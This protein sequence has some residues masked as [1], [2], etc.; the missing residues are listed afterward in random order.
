MNARYARLSC[1]SLMLT[2]VAATGLAGCSGSAV[3]PTAY[4]EYNARDGTF[5]CARPEGWE[6]DGGGKNG[7]Q[8]A[9]F[10]SGPA[11]IRI[12][13]DLVGSLM[14]GIPSGSLPEGMEEVVELEPVHRVHELEKRDA[15]QKYPGYAEVGSPQV[16]K[17]T[18]GPARQ[19]EFTA[20]STFG[21]GLHGYRVTVLGHDK[22]VEVYAVCPE[23]DWQAMKP[24]FDKVIASLVRGNPE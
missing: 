21:T 15:E 8:W 2:V 6:Y 1:I 4:G 9:T 19:S 3:V 12:S 16:I 14:G 20:S 17:V 11:E 7:P 13:A 23:S 10:Q 18:L 5:A 24:A 22:R